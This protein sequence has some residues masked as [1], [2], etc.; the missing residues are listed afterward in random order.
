M[1]VYEYKA[2]LEN[3]SHTKGV[4]DADTAREARAKLRA[5]QVHV[6]D[7]RVLGGGVPGESEPAAR[8]VALAAS[9]QGDPLGS[10]T[11]AHGGIGGTVLAALREVRLPRLDQARVRSEVSAFTRQL[12]TLLGAGITLAEAIS[13]LVQQVSSRRL[14][15]VLRILREDIQSGLG[16]A[17]AMARHPHMFT[18]L[19]VNMVRA[20][21]ASGNLDEILSRL[22]DYL[23]AQERMR[24]RVATAL[25]YPAIMAVAGMGVVVFLLTYVVPKITAVILKR[26]NVLPL[27]TQMLISIQWFVTAYYPFILGG[28]ALGYGLLRLFRATERG[29][30]IWDT[31]KLKL[32]I[33]GELFQKQSVSRF[34]V[35]FA[36]LLKS[37]IQATDALRILR[38]VVDNKLLAVTLQDVHDRILQGADIS[39]PLRASSVF[40]PVVG[41][42]IAVGERSGSLEDMLERISESYDEE[43]EL[44]TQKVTAFIEPVIIVIMAGIVGFIVLAVILPLVQGFNV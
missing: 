32:P 44:T 36:T 23:Q 22:S 24:N 8:S 16:L 37:G 40:P 13:V 9:R 33:F 17:D 11:S 29:A 28:L 18:D 6:T 3:G 14:E 1:P 5:R 20:G 26:G 12:A 25:T 21:E 39:A 41:Y 4:V 42:M 35:T 27:P 19:Y 38:N 30:L 7:M 10:L 15:T 34:A 43:I 2:L 31:Y